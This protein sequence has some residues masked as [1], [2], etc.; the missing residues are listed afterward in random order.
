MP[1]VL[2]LAESPNSRRVSTA[3]IT[4]PIWK[5]STFVGGWVTQQVIPLNDF[6]GLLCSRRWRGIRRGGRSFGCRSGNRNRI[7]GS[8]Y[9]RGAKAVRCHLKRRL[10]RRRNRSNLH[11]RRRSHSRRVGRDR[12]RTWDR[13]VGL[14]GE[15]LFE[16][17]AALAR[18][19]HVEDRE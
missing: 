6:T 7:R 11:D 14:T 19:L 16:S 3:V 1:S 10:G 4:R 2:R 18:G 8:S 13:G 15:L 12:E 5:P 17:A 9:V